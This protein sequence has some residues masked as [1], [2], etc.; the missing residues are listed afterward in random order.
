MCSLNYSACLTVIL[1]VVFTTTACQQERRT[2]VRIEGDNIPRFVLSGSGD[3]TVLRVF[4][5]PDKYAADGIVWEI[6]P[7][8]EGAWKTVDDLGVIVYG[9][10]PKSYVQKQPKEGPAPSLVEGIDYRVF[11]GTVNAPTATKTFTIRNNKAIDT[12]SD[13]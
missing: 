2:K 12:T 4:G 1:A 8:N 13:Q 6:V 10:I 9:Q 11:V 3:L 5:P 7:Q